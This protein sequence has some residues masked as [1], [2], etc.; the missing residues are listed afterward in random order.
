MTIG[1]G[2]IT[3]SGN[4]GIVKIATVNSGSG[5]LWTDINTGDNAYSSMPS[6]VA[7]MNTADNTTNSFAGVFFQAGEDSSGLA[8]SSA[9]IGAIRTGSATTDLSFATRG[10]GGMR[11]RLR[12]FSGGDISFYDDTGSTQG[13]FWDASA[14]R[15]GLGTTSPSEKLTVVGETT[16]GSGTYGTKL[17]YSNGNQS[18]IIDTFGNHNLEFRA[19]NDR[20]MNIANNGD[21]SFYEDT[22]TTAKLFWDASTRS[23]L[24]TV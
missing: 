24:S 4:E 13:L 2:N 12:V 8:I 19:N 6:E 9:R 18:G 16:S 21:I 20:A 5:T 3:A 22:G 15:L 14:E 10:V 7:I 11:D 1:S 23:E 17:T